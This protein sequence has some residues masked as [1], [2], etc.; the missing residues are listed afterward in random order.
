MRAIW[1]IF[2]VVVN[3]K[4]QTEV[5]K[6]AISTKQNSTLSS[7]HKMKNKI[8]DTVKTVPMSKRTTNQFFV[9]VMFYYFEK[10]MFP[11]LKKNKIFQA[12]RCKIN[13]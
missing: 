10:N 5:N 11:N 6:Q 9:G 7:D 13:K 3:K 4:V 1:K 8:Y 2:I 12:G